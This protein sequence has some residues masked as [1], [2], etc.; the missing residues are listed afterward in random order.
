MPKSC[1][2]NPDDMKTARIILF[3]CFFPL[4]GFCQQL[5]G[6]WT[7]TLSNDSN[8]IRKDQS[9][10]IALTQYKNKVYGYSYT[11]FMVHDTLFYIVKRVKGKVDGDICE[12]EDDEITSCNFLNKIDKGVK[13][14]FTFR[15]NQA[16][17]LWR[18]DGDWK[19]GKTKKYYA[20]SG[21]VK[22]TEQK[23]L[24][25]SKLY[26][27]LQE[28]NL[29]DAIASS[30]KQSQPG[31]SLAANNTTGETQQ[32][33]AAS[34]NKKNKN[35]EDRALANKTRETDERT[36]AVAEKPAEAG[37][38]SIPAIPAAD[39]SHRTSAVIET[40]PVI[41]DSL[42]LSL[43]DNGEIDGDTVSVLLNGEL[44][45]AKQGLKATAIKKTIYLDPSQGDS[46]RLVLYAE[47]LGAYPPNTGLL[48]I[49]DAGNVYQ[50]R[51][52]ADLQKNAA[53][54]FT[55]KKKQ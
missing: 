11:T 51:F 24:S 40:I 4:V 16:D 33:K 5:T 14:H 25:K 8:T 34:S 18:L 37:V 35:K 41:G 54:I 52:S 22:T 26:P 9:F 38:V 20:V 23:N 28:L 30:Q 32:L 39:V 53:I 15:L 12:V 55:R 6:L 29:A 19:T 17:S 48:I 13:Q 36:R 21:S 3:F 43:Y 42:S 2:F 49:H 1:F 50:V 31:E 44:I 47:N 27:H 45:M 10:E 46:I 7:G